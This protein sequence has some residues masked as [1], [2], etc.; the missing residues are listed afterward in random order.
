MDF[1]LIQSY[2]DKIP[3]LD[4][5]TV[6]PEVQGMIDKYGRVLVEEKINKILDSRHLEISTAKSEKNVKALDFSMIFYIEALTEFLKEERV[7]S[8]NKI[9]NCLGTVYSEALGTKIYSKDILKDFT[10]GYKGYNNLRY[11]LTQSKEIKLNEEIEKILKSYSNDGDYLL[12]SN[13][14]GAFYSILNTCY[15]GYEVISSVRESYSFEKDLDLNTL[16]EN[17][18]CTK[19]V[20]GN[21]NNISINDYNKNYNENSF[22]VLSDFFGNSLEGLAKLKD[23]EIKELL[24]KERT[25]FLS[26]KFYFRNEN[27]EFSSKGLEFSKF[28]N[29]KALI[30]ADLSKSEDLPDCIVLAGSKALIKKIRESIY[31]KIFYPS[32][33]TETLF[34]LGIE[35]KISENKDNSYLKKVLSTDEDKLKNRNIKFIKSLEKELGNICDIGLIE[36]PYLKVEENVSYRDAYNRELVVIT[37]KE[38]KVEE[39]EFE[40][41]NSDPAILCW[42]NDGSLLINLQLVDERENKILLETL[43]KAILK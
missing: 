4:E 19:K 15:K 32:R 36:G 9:I 26:D 33:E 24:S 8:I 7:Q 30:L 43:I 18:N 2:L 5:L 10:E 13:F 22:I 3:K 37:P 29:N 1:M 35:K 23:N 21:L 31:S 27:S 39:I 17:M 25:V 16:L 38:K 6:L 40:L 28:I 41:R 42:I 20:V 14:S 12:F 11:D 34:Y